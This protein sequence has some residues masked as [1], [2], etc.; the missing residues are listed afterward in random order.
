MPA[1]QSVTSA[2]VPLDGD[3]WLLVY[4]EPYGSWCLTDSPQMKQRYDHALS[5]M[6]LRD[7]NHPSVVIWGLSNETPDGPVFRNAAESLPLVRSM[8]NA[9]MVML[10][11]GRWAL[12]GRGDVH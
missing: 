4:Q 11:S 3:D 9:R 2:V 12:H 1:G 5:G 7:R 8:D 10:N 6:I